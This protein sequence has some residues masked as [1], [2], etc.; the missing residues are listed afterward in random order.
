MKRIILFYTLLI[1]ALAYGTCVYAEEDCTARERRAS[2][3]IWRVDPGCTP[4]LFTVAH[5]GTAGAPS[6]TVF[7]A[8]GNL[9]VC[10]TDRTSATAYRFSEHQAE[11]GSTDNVTWG[12][13]NDRWYDLFAYGDA[14]WAQHPICKAGDQA[15]QWAALTKEQW[16]Y[17]FARTDANGLLYAFCT[18]NVNVK[19]AE[20]VKEAKNVSGVL[21]LPDKYTDPTGISLTRGTKTFATNHLTEEQWNSL[22]AVGVVF[23]PCTG[24]MTGSTGSYEM[25]LQDVAD[26]GYYWTATEKDGETAYA[27]TFSDNT[28]NFATEVPKSTF[29]AVRAYYRVFT[30]NY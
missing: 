8:Q 16:Q 4:G 27:I 30:T 23:L 21:L 17:L 28:L 10:P 25:T 24:H 20:G 14:S 7:L 11:V 3:S 9:Q 13:L 19:I 15:N 29:C 5:T 6:D 1:T 26:H 2:A 22:S 12:R 18:M